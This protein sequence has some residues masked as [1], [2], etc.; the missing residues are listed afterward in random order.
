M[1]S[2]SIISTEGLS[3]HQKM[4]QHINMT[5]Y[6]TLIL[7]LLSIFFGTEKTAW[8]R[9]KHA[10]VTFA[11]QNHVASSTLSAFVFDRHSGQIIF[12]H[13][14]DQVQNSRLML[15]LL[16]LSAVYDQSMPLPKPKVPIET[17]PTD[18]PA[19]NE[20][21]A[22]ANPGTTDAGNKSEQIEAEQSDPEEQ[23][24]RREAITGN[25]S[26]VSEKQNLD[27]Q[28]TTISGA[29]NINK[30]SSSSEE[31][32]IR[33][34]SLPTAISMLNQT[35]DD[36]LSVLFDAQHLMLDEASSEQKNKHSTLAESPT[37]TTPISHRAIALSN[38]T[39]FLK[40]HDMS[41]DIAKKLH[42]ESFAVKIG[43][44]DIVRYLNRA[45]SDFRWGIDSLAVLP[46]ID[47]GRGKQLRGIIEHEAT[48]ITIFGI[49]MSTKTM[50]QRVVALRIAPCTRVNYEK[51]YQ[52]IK[53]AAGLF[54]D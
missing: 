38:M 45:M 4:I 34:P 14:S 13:L 32:D 25:S 3:Y 33:R 30:T 2:P 15:R 28:L 46:T 18:Q 39:T 9:K 6:V 42:W 12:E 17:K 16:L 37:A 51:N 49:L 5:G 31:Q 50:Q 35:H 1:N 22:I 29:P 23:A 43:T 44:G 19:T 40:R 7:L 11:N 26:G 21:T 27:E 52:W 48:S 20:D 10:I 47:L 36:P 8:S 24:E 41:F 53:L 54:L